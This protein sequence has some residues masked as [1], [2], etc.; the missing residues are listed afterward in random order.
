MEISGG[1]SGGRENMAALI[2]PNTFSKI[3][4]ISGVTELSIKTTA[5]SWKTMGSPRRFSFALSTRTDFLPT[6]TKRRRKSHVRVVSCERNLWE[7]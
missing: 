1:F 2:E 6:K 3:A 7:K 5:S 4:E